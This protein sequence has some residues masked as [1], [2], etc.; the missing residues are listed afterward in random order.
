[1]KLQKRRWRDKGRK[2]KKMLLT[3]QEKNPKDS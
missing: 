1:M 3:A 2:K